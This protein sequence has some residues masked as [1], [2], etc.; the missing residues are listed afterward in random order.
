MKTYL[1]QEQL[2]QKAW[3][4][5]QADIDRE[6]WIT[7]EAN[8]LY[9]AISDEPAEWL[10]TENIPE[11]FS[12]VINGQPGKEAFRDFLY[13]ICLLKATQHYGNWQ[14]WA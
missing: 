5:H 14:E 1:L 11:G 4:A 6:C 9:T 13:D 8:K 10:I 2:E 3:D 7:D 12:S